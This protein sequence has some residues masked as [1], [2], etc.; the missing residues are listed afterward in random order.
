MGMIFSIWTVVVFIFFIGVVFWAYSSKRKE[1]FD[2]AARI[3]F[4]EHEIDINSDIN[5]SDNA[6]VEKNNG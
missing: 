6:L 1:D 4:D 2:E 3:P 5:L